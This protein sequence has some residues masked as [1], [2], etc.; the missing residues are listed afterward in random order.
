[1]GLNISQICRVCG[2]GKVIG[3]DV[4]DESLKLA[5]QLGA[6][7]T[8]NARNVDPVEAVRE[9]T[10]GWGAD[11][12]FE[13]AGGSTRQGLSG[14]KTLEQAINMVREG[15]KI[16]EVAHPVANATVPARTLE[17]KNY[18][19][20][21]HCTPKLANY[22]IQLVASKRVQLIPMITHVL[23]GIEKVPE[24]FEIT[25]NKGKYGGINPAQVVISRGK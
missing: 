1:M 3:I 16:V 9:N 24:A 11:I 23:E 15:G 7:V 14:S 25:G 22:V 20:A 13:C 12:V 21:R 19:A 4:R 8:I 18:I 17:S 6:D 2:A 10:R 5:S